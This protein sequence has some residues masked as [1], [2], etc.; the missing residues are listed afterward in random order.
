MTQPSFSDGR[1]G[2]PGTLLNG[3]GKA[4]E[5]LGVRKSREHVVDGDAGGQFVGHGLGPG[6]HGSTKRVRESNVRDGFLYRGRNDLDDSPVP[7][8]LHDGNSSFHQRVRSVEV[9][10]ERGIEITDLVVEQRAAGRSTRVVDEDMNGSEGFGSRRERSGQPLGLFEIQ[11]ECL[12][13]PIAQSSKLL[14]QGG[15]CS[16][17][18]GADGDVGACLGHHFGRCFADAFACAANE[19][20][21]AAEGRSCKRIVVAQEVHALRKS[22]W[23]IALG[24]SPVLNQNES[25]Q[26]LLRSNQSQSSTVLSWTN[27]SSEATSMMS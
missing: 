11:H 24:L 2:F 14:T 19:R 18:S 22:P 7:F 23:V 13:S 4:A 5:P 6:G 27:Q 25:L 9:A 1:S 15:Q 20:V 21:L 26:A 17:V 3:G 8:C 10:S 16:A 12:V